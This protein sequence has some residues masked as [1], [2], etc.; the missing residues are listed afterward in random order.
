VEALVVEVLVVAGTVEGAVVEVLVVEA[1]VVAGTVEGAVVEV[2]VEVLMGGCV[3]AWVEAV[4]RRAV[5][6]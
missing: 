3:G 4:R 2:L 5:S 1:T 6:G